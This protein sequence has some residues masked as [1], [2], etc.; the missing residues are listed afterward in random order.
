MEK[1]TKALIEEIND[2]TSYS[3]L[4]K[5]QKLIDVVINNDF[6]NSEKIRSAVAETKKKINTTELKNKENKS[7]RPLDFKRLSDPY[8][9][10]YARKPQKEIEEDEGILEVEYEDPEQEIKKETRGRKP[11]K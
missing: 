7:Y 11:K 4:I 1:I 8:Y 5:L 6:R 9:N 2:I 3:D 10:P